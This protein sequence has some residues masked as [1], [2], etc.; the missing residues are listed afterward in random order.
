MSAKIA[1]K[2]LKLVTQNEAAKELPRILLSW[3]EHPLE[4]YLKQLQ[5]Q[6]EQ[7]S[8]A[9]FE[10]AFCAVQ[11]PPATPALPNASTTWLATTQ[12]CPPLLLPPPLNEEWFLDVGADFSDL[13]RTTCLTDFTGGV[14]GAQVIQF[15]GG[16]AAQGMVLPHPKKGTHVLM[17]KG[18]ATIGP[19]VWPGGNTTLVHVESGDMVRQHSS[20]VP[21]IPYFSHGLACSCG[22]AGVL[23]LGRWHRRH[24]RCRGQEP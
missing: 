1:N 11:T 6:V 20:P 15:N 17:A 9:L 3:E 22:G 24:C 10:R 5:T 7:G 2:E 16:K 13:T 4:Q 8:Y 14:Y 18:G 23:G 21:R 12:D 19:R